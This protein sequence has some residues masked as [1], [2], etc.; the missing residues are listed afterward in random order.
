LLTKLGIP[1]NQ[2]SSNCLTE[3]T[4][5]IVSY[6]STPSINNYTIYSLIGSINSP[7]QIV[8]KKFKE[9]KRLGQTYYLL[10][11]GPEKL[12]ALSENIADKEDIP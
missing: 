10:K 7:E 1:T 6:Y 3:L 9:G 4:K 8:E 2:L 5:K 12:Q 11:V